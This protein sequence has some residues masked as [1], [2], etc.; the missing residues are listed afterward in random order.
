MKRFTLDTGY[1]WILNIIIYPNVGSEQHSSNI[2]LT[3]SKIEIHSESK[4]RY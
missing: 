1:N 2:A 3:L 4:L